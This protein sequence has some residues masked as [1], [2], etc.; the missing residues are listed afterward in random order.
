[1]K[2]LAEF[3]Q[4]FCTIISNI[5]YSYNCNLAVNLTEFP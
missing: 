2:N 3:R 5:A 4:Y 1:M